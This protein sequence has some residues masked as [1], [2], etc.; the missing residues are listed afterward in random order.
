MNQGF[1]QKGEIYVNQ[2]LLLDFDDTEDG[3]TGQIQK[4]QTGGREV[5]LK[6]LRN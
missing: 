6:C 4:T 5:R 3:S 2:R 1:T